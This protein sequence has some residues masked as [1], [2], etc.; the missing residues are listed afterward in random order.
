MI[1]R[2]IKT[3]VLCA[4]AACT[5]PTEPCPASYCSN[6]GECTSQTSTPICACDT[7]YEGAVCERCAAG[8]H[9][10]GE[11][12]A[13]DTT[14]AE[15]TC[16][17]GTCAE[18]DGRAVCTCDAG[19]EG[20]RCATCY[21]PYLAVPVDAAVPN[22][23]FTCEPPQQCN[24]GSCA[25][26]FT[27]DDTGGVVVCT[28]AGPGCSACTESTCGT[29]GTCDDSTGNTRCV[30][31]AGYQ[32]ASCASCYPG[33]HAVGDTC[34]RDERCEPLTCSSVGV[35]SAA[36]GI[37]VCT[38]PSEY[39]G[40]G[41]ERCAADHHRN[42][43]GACVIDE[44]CGPSACP[45]NSQCVVSGG[46]VTCPCDDGYAGQT[47]AQCYPGFHQDGGACVLDERCSDG[48]P[49]GGG[50]CEDGTGIVVCSACPTGYSG[51]HCEVNTDDCGS[52]C[53][54]G[55]CID[56]VNG[57][58]CLCTD[59]TWGSSCPAGPTITNVAP[60][61][62]PLQ[63]GGSITITGTGFGGTPTV[64]I[65]GVAAVIGAATSSSI[66][67]TVPV[68]ASVGAKELRVVGINAQVAKTTYTYTPIVFSYTGANQTFTVPASG[69][70]AIT[71]AAWGAGGGGGEDTTVVGGAG[72]F[73]TG[74]IAVSASQ[75]FTIVVGGGG[76]R[77]TSM[78]MTAAGAG[79]GYSG[80]F[81]GGVAQANA[82]FIAGGGGGGGLASDATFGAAGGNGGG[83]FGGE[84]AVSGSTNYDARGLGGSDVAGGV[85]G[86]FMAM[87]CGQ[88]G[89]ALLG[90]GGGTTN[91][92][93]AG[94]TYGGG[95]GAGASTTGY[96]GGGGGGY[97]G[98]GGGAGIAGS[99]GGGGSGFFHANVSGGSTV[100]SSVPGVPSGQTQLGYVA[101]A[102]FGGQAQSGPA[103]GQ[104][105][106]VVI[107]W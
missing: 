57:H 92:T 44:T 80:V 2:T 62:G 3:L 88:N 25:P 43:N 23:A 6:R 10:E 35:C 8:F 32:G 68:G 56:L 98:G 39:A 27:C 13:V 30:C 66:T 87:T 91:L 86:C 37:A 19:Y 1:M 89:L 74:A 21:G 93:L 63:G 50:T 52:V 72:G 31:N 99:G 14:C 36:T 95:G 100:R 48:L 82:R 60:N 38:C 51:A 9:R 7:G 104:D 96:A 5:A 45:L 11:S 105:G 24:A 102:G 69:V 83:Q 4:L 79:G 107:S 94:A 46:V 70:S 103:K 20:A 22:G 85:G 59:G 34:V 15:D 47:C 90:G 33:Y 53:Q 101:P 61:R 41:C 55:Q 54:T 58:Q 49:C 42:N 28:C 77:V 78:N 75:V 71:V 29:Y 67:V 84:G 73:T 16:V 81:F 64:T 18:Q 12:C 97:F 40:V 76:A 17:H 65:G 26:G 106:L